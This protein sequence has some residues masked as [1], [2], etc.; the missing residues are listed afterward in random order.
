MTKYPLQSRIIH[1]L[2]ALVLVF[3]FFSGWYMVD[4]DYYSNWYQT[5][6]DVHQLIGVGLLCLWLYKIIRLFWIT[7][8]S[9]IA[10]LKPAEQLAA[11]AV[12]LLFYLL[13]MLLCCTGYLMSTGGDQHAL[14]DLITLPSL[15]IFESDTLDLLGS[16]HK[17]MAYSIM[18]LVLL[19]M[20]AALKHHFYDKDAT[21]RRML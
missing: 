4:L 6:P 19:H 18:I 7:N 13:V 17:Y 20:L 3:L 2:S 21:L 8:P 15:I 14:L 11:S 16:T 5:L 10:T 12:K 1:W 9:P